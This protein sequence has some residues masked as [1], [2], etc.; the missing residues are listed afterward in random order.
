M[1][2]TEAKLSMSDFPLLDVVVVCEFSSC[3]N[4]L[5]SNPP[6][7]FCKPFKPLC[8]KL[9]KASTKSCAAVTK[10]AKPFELVAALCNIPSPRVEATESK[11]PSDEM[12][13]IVAF[14]IVAVLVIVSGVNKL[15][16]GWALAVSKMPVCKYVDE[17]IFEM[18]I[19]FS[20]DKH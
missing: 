1:I 5:A 6:A 11:L 4:W 15:V 10:V 2:P 7:G 8:R 9:L 12:S 19:T 16:T 14:G 17:R 13:T 18:F 3:K 20:L